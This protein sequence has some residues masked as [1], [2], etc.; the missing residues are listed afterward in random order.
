MTNT[1]LLL[2]AFGIGF[3][4]GLRTMTA[5]AA[6]S[7]AAYLGWLNLRES[8][9]WFMASGIAVTIVSTLAVVEYIVD[10]LPTTP[11]RTLLGPLAGRIIMGGFAG[12][13]LAVSAGQ[14]FVIGAI[15][16]TIGALVGTYGGY[17]GRKRLVQALKVKDAPIA[18]LEDLIAIGLACLIVFQRH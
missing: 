11:S 8:S 2:A 5:P 12:A 1:S 10:K 14:S 18:I 16:G 15:P 9:L 7:W 13:C 6:V 17:E 3:V 4:A